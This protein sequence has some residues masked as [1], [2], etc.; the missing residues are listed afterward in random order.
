MRR[1]G[2]G[3]V[4]VALVAAI[5]LVAIA[6]VGAIADAPVAPPV[7][8]VVD[9]ATTGA[10]GP[11]AVVGAQLMTSRDAALMPVPLASLTHP[12]ARSRSQERLWLLAL[13]VLVVGLA[14]SPS[15]THPR[16]HG[17]ARGPADPLVRLPGRRGP[18]TRR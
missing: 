9:T 14:T 16:R 1:W 15:G 17:R 6:P 12:F 4:A 13:L 2:H 5:A 10:L 3:L 7:T 11:P 18:P 8:A